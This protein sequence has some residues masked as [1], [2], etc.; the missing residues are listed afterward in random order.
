MA[1]AKKKW[2][3]FR[4]NAI[5]PASILGAKTDK[6][7]NAREPVQVP[8]GYADH[9]VHDRFADECE[10]PK[11][12]AK[13]ATSMPPAGQQNDDAAAKAK[14]VAAAQAVVDDLKTKMSGMNEDNP[15]WEG[16][17]GQLDEAVTAL[18]EAQEAAK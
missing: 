15:E 18:A 5:I 14:A 1:A 3:A 4:T 11:R 13:P 16:L 17:K 6:K 10:A 12:V 8:A 7:V 9:V 2:V